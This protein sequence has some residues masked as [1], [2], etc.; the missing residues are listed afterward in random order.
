MDTLLIVIILVLLVLGSV[1]LIL[2][3]TRGSKSSARIE[4]RLAQYV[5]NPTTM[6]ELELMLPFSERVLAPVILK[7]ARSASRLTPRSN[8]E[9]LK[10]NLLEAGSPSKVG[11]SEFLGLRLVV[12]GVAGG[13]FFLMFVVTGASLGQLLLFP[14]VIAGIGYMIPGI[15]LSRKIKARKNEIQMSLPDAIDLLTISVEAGLGFDPALQRVAE[16]WDNELTREF[17]RMLSEIRMGKSRREALR[18]M[19]NRVNIDDLNVFIASVVQADQLGVSISQV[20]RVQ[21]KQ[22]R[23]RRRQRAEEKAHKAPIKMLFP[24]IL[25][26][27]PAMYVVI[28]GPAI[29][30][31]MGGF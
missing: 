24:M 2:M 15:W 27:F 31:I 11:P 7:V 30:Q 1:A 23:L 17:R 4:E 21:S 20:L 9:K 25:L 5:D 14:L 3:G 12:G 8:I 26:I 10:Q 28:L 18:E 22:M 16:K 6:E 19:A 13:A 29:P